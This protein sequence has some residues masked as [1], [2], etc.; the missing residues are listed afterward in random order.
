MTLSAVRTIEHLVALDATSGATSAMPAVREA[1]RRVPELSVDPRA[2]GALR[3]HGTDRLAVLAELGEVIGWILFDAGFFREAHRMNARALALAEL[4]GDR[5]TARFVLLND[6]ML[7][8]HTGAPRTALE[9]AARVSGTREL[10][11]RVSSLVLIRKAHAIAMLGGQREPMDLMSRA[12]SRFLDGVSRHDPRWAW[13]IDR[14]EL[15]GHQGWVLAR[16]HRWDQAIALLHEAATAPGP[17]YRNLFTA[18]LLAALSRAGAWKEAEDL[19]AEVAPRA[20]RIGSVRTTQT[21]GRTASRLLGRP[22]VPQP[23]R[24]AAAFLLE[25]LPAPEVTGSPPRPVAP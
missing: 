19:I 15:L 9:S 22:G 4:C 10:P 12:Q 5:W 25:S 3:G 14:T 24:E 6:S 17:A 16:L 11:A 23:L 8:A 7:K 1:V 18:Q 13:W 20:A 2:V 21:L